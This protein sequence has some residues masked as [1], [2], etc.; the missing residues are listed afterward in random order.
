MFTVLYVMNIVGASAIHY[1]ILQA[2]SSA[3]GTILSIP[4]GKLSDRKGMQGRKPYV[5]IMFLLTAIYPLL[6]VLV[7]STGWL[8][9]IFLMWGVRQSFD[10]A[11][12]AM[13]VDLAGSRERGR[14]LG[15]YFLINGLAAFPSSFVAGWLYQWRATAPFLIGSCI[16]FLGFLIFLW[17]VPSRSENTV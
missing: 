17:R 4:V 3:A 15:V 13:I 5:M 9:P 12:K 16:S 7:P 11:R 1:G 10:L 6:L 14:V 8:F 2:V